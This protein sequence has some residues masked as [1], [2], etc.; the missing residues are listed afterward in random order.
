MNTTRNNRI[1]KIIEIG[2]YVPMAYNEEISTYQDRIKE[3]DYCYNVTTA[4]DIF[5]FYSK[6]KVISLPVKDFDWKILWDKLGNIP[7]NDNGE[8][9]EI[10]EHFEVG[11]D[12]EDVWHWFEWFFDISIGKE[13]FN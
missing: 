7:V 12:R 10:F 11:T 9:E 5:H 8:I 13:M 4:D 1:S 3:N 2:V 6:D